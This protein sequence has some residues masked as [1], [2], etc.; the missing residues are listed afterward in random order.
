M[1]EL[2]RRLVQIQTDRGLTNA[3]FARMLGVNRA[4]WS[5]VRS[6]SREPGKK[7]IEGAFR[8]WP[9]LSYVYA[10]ALQISTDT[11]ADRDGHA[12]AVAS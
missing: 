2:V 3:E 4:M 10:Q 11:R 5:M 7:I 9:E 6:G 8:L 12:E 1:S